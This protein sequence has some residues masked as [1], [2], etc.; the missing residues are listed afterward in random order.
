MLGIVAG[1]GLFLVSSRFL[2]TLVFGVT[3]NDAA[4]L[5]V[6][7]SALATVAM[8]ASWIPARRA[9]AVDPIEA[10]RRE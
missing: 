7:V 9:A 4:T 8:I 10:L 3:T 2:K 6:V 1:T 5:A